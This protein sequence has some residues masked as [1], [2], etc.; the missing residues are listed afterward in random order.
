MVV[1]MVLVFAGEWPHLS[2]HFWE[3]V[4]ILRGDPQGPR[5]TFALSAD[6][7][8][9]ELRG[10]INAGS[11]SRLKVLLDANPDVTLITLT[12]EGGR[13]LE[14]L[15]MANLVRERGLSTR[16]SSFCASAATLPFIAGR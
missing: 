14:G 1:I 6:R 3:Q 2:T 4:S 11:A 10:G 7:T 5:C 15:V 13:V 12:S 8:E 9:L 16:C